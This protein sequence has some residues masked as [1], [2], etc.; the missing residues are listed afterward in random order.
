MVSTSD[1]TSTMDQVEYGDIFTTL[2]DRSTRD[3]YPSMMD[4]DPYFW[5]AHI[6]ITSC[7]EAVYQVI[8]YAQTP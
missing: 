3:T 2:W 7:E 5:S 8:F 1:I 6:W 4:D